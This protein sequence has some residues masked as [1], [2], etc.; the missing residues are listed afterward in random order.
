M[1]IPL[2]Q[3][4][5][6]NSNALNN[7]IIFNSNIETRCSFPTLTKHYNSFSHYSTELCVTCHLTMDFCRST[8]FSETPIRNMQTLSFRANVTDKWLREIGRSKNVT[9]Q[10]VRSILRIYR[11][12]V[13]GS[14]GLSTHV[15]F[16]HSLSIPYPHYRFL[17]IYQPIPQGFILCQAY[18]RAHFTYK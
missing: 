17:Q 6:T 14:Y 13:K 9:L 12:C 10:V 4:H 16:P 5:D 7:L 8:W 11:E 1:C 2:N 3:L 18:A 15:R